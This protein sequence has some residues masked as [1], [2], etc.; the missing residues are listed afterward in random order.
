MTTPMKVKI[1]TA[2]AGALGGL[3]VAIGVPLMMMSTLNVLFDASMS[4]KNYL[5][6]FACLYTTRE[7]IN[8]I[9]K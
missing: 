2:L 7:L 9:Y 1:I 6:V 5:I 4:L 3:F 8:E